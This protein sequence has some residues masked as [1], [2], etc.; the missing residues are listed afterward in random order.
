MPRANA[1]ARSAERA[2]IRF[3]IHVFL[4]DTLHIDTFHIHTLPINTFRPLQRT[5]TLHL[6]ASPPSDIESP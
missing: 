5:S 3:R 6:D 2:G 1:N 4:I